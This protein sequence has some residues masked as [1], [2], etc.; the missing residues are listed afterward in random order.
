MIANYM[1]EILYSSLADLVAVNHT[2][3]LVN[4]DWLYDTFTL[5][6]FHNGHC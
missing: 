2:P 4:T 5:A 6:E 1:V 3:D